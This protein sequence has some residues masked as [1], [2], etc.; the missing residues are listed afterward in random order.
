M[1]PWAMASPLRALQYATVY[2]WRAGGKNM[3]LYLFYNHAQAQFLFK[4]N[5]TQACPD[6]DQGLW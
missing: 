4:C 6:A 2:K 1:L 5:S 3:Q